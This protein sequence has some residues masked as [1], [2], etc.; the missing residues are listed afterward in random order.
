LSYSP[1]PV[2]LTAREEV[3]FQ[4]WEADYRDHLP[5]DARASRA[6][7]AGARLPASMAWL[8]RRMAG[9]SKMLARDCRA[10]GAAGHFLAMSVRETMTVS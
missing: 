7:S 5:R 6:T 2:S 1:T 4:P 9:S 3:Q 10:A 8:R